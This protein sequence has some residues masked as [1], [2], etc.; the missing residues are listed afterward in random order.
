MTIMKMNK[1]MEI[2]SE[3]KIVLR[4]FLRM[5]LFLFDAI[6]KK[7]NFSKSIVYHYEGAICMTTI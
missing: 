7:H 1:K 6:I 3:N 4:I 2:M 5:K